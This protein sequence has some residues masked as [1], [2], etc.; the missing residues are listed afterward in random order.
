[1]AERKKGFFGLK[2]ETKEDL[3]S[4]GQ[5]L[6]DQ[7]NT[8]DKID[9]IVNNTFKVKKLAAAAAKSSLSLDKIQKVNC[10]W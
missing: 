6:K 3:R 1:M 2:S 9:E 8:T 5:E 10:C 4:I 7:L